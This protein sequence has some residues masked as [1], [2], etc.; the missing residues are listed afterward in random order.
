MAHSGSDAG[1]RL[2]E[3]TDDDSVDPDERNYFE[4]VNI[5]QESYK[6]L[7]ETCFFCTHWR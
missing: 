4:I 2:F 1:K 7:K 3:M 6:E 5:N